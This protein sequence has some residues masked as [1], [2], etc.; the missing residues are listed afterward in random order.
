MRFRIV[1][2]PVI[3]LCQCSGLCPISVYGSNKNRNGIRIKNIRFA[4]LT[5]AMLMVLLINCIVYC[6]YSSYFVRWKDSA[7]LIIIAM[8]VT[9]TIRAHTGM[10]LIESYKNRSIQ[11]QLLKKYDE[12]ES[13]FTTKLK[14]KT[15]DARVRRR[16]FSF[17][18]IWIVK[19]AL[20]IS[21]PYLCGYLTSNRRTI[22]VISV[23][24][25]PIYFS[26]LFYAQLMVYLDLVRY[27]LEMINKCLTKLKDPPQ[28]H[29][30]RLQRQ[31]ICRF[32]S[33]IC[34]ISQQL[35]HLRICYNKT[36]EAAMLI[37]RYAR[38]SLLL[39]VNNDFVFYVTNLYWILYFLIYLSSS[40]WSS[41]VIFMM[42]AAMNTSHFVQLSMI[43][44]QI[45][46]QVTRLSTA[47]YR[48]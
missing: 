30:L 48:I 29:W 26:T 25:V 4:A 23:A 20:C 22:N 34:D 37:N 31:P 41:L 33:E 11:L 7:I 42:F 15:N 38:W 14:M 12:I 27:N 32:T 13:V 45:M 6:V 19:V 3:R 18:F 46:E 36:W 40:T 5:M 9:I 43:C 10:V 2:K 47:A 24:L 17:I 39:G 44:E 1:L 28:I 8:L 16:C 35:I 21:I